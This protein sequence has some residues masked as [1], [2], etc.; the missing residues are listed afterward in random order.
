MRERRAAMLEEL[1]KAE[2]VREKLLALDEVARTYPEG[3]DMR[4]R[5]ESMNLARM[6]DQVQ[7]DID[8]RR[9]ALLHPSGF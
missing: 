2:R 9:E 3:H 4:V 1:L 7:D 5:L 8:T 6:L